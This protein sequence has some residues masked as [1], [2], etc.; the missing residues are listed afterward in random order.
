MRD[1]G[2]EGKVVERL[3]EGGKSEGEIEEKLGKGQ[4]EGGRD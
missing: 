2:K 4:R 1:R 3:R